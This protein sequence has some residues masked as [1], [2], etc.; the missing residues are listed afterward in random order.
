[1]DEEFQD[2]IPFMDYER[3]K[4]AGNKAVPT[5]TDYD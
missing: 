5:N 2:I 4:K 3:N 1:L